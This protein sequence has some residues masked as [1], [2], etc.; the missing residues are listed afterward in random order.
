MLEVVEHAAGEGVGAHRTHVKPAGDLFESR[1]ELDAAGIGEVH[2]HEV[3]LFPN[4][5]QKQPTKF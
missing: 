5:L 1:R 3:R 2:E 4:Q